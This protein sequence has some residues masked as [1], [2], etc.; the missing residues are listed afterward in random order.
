V[1]GEIRPVWQ[2]GQVCSEVV[3]Q[4]HPKGIYRRDIRV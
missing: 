2:Q 4:D 1:R 3:I